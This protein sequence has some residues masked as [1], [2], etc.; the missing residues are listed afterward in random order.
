MSTRRS[1][2]TVFVDAP[3]RHDPA[4]VWWRLASGLALPWW[5]QPRPP[6]AEAILS[7]ETGSFTARALHLRVSDETFF[8]LRESGQPEKREHHDR[9]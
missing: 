4:P 6:W 7:Q 5:P 9:T 8:Q 1:G 3:W 2:A